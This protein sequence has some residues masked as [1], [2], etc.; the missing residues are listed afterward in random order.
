MASFLAAMVSCNWLASASS[1]SKDCSSASMSKAS[2]SYAG[3]SSAGALF[4]AVESSEC[5]W[6]CPTA[7]IS[8]KFSKRM[9]WS[10]ELAAVRLNSLVRGAVGIVMRVKPRVVAEASTD[11][12][13]RLT[14]CVTC[15]VLG[16]EGS[17]GE[18]VDVSPDRATRSECERPRRS[19]AVMWRVSGA[20]T[21]APGVDEC[22]VH[23]RSSGDSLTEMLEDV[24]SIDWSTRTSKT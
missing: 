24:G 10:G 21:N 7:G 5:R 4:V 18:A 22:S 23:L 8:S 6:C 13:R 3:G 16:R 1:R 17:D 2:S 19:N 20:T 9:G 15:V 12:M 11:S 14:R